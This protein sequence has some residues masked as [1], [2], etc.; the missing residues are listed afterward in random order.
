M[1]KSKVMTVFERVEQNTEEGAQACTW[2][3][4][5]W[6]TSPNQDV[7]I[8]LFV[9]PYLSHSCFSFN[10]S[11]SYV[12]MRIGDGESILSSFNQDI[13]GW[14]RQHNTDQ[15]VINH[16]TLKFFTTM[17]DNGISFS[18]PDSPNVNTCFDSTIPIFISMARFALTIFFH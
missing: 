4:S 10:C 18:W 8:F 11:D 5:A 9:F 6:K 14:R 17:N 13:N 16:T 15:A 3:T 2:W 7:P 12:I 1:K